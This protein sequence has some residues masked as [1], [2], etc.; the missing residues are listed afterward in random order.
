MEFNINVRESIS[1]G[2]SNS[3]QGIQNSE[4]LQSQRQ[5]A[6]GQGAGCGATWKS[7]ISFSWLATEFAHRI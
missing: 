5:Q 6:L 4:E 1:W 2:W 3:S 7:P